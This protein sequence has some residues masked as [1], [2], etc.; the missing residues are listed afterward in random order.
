MRNI[1]L[2]SAQILLK[3]RPTERQLSNRLAPPVPDG[4]ELYLDRVDL[5]GD[6]WLERIQRVIRGAEAPRNALW[7]VEGPTRT[8]GGSYFDLTED[9]ADHRETVRRVVEAGQTIGAVAANVHIVAPTTDAEEL[10]L[11]NRR[12]KL[13]QAIPLLEYYVDLCG[14][15]GMIPQVENI[16]P[17][18]RMRECAFVFSSIGAI[19]SDVLELIETLPALRLT[20]DVS[21]AGLALNWQRIELA[22]VPPELRSVAEFSRSLDGPADLESWLGAVGGVTTTIHVSNASGLLGEGL[23]YDDGDEDL[24]RV[25]KPV[26]GSIRY[27]VTE[28]LESDPER[29]TGM[30]AVQSRLL[31]LRASR[32]KRSL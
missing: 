30:R 31:A 14:Q 26:L 21:H 22:D 28:T 10:T 2:P 15:A 32:A 3:A 4:L 1:G 6:N 7:I 29:A 8:L 18:G 19:P 23:G 27:L 24:D 25:L 20:A 17:V 11:T 16:P 12:R 13:E 5:A 9:D